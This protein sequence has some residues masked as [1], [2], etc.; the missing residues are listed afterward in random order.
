[1]VFFLKMYFWDLAA[2]FFDFVVLFWDVLVRIYFGTGFLDVRDW[3]KR[4][5][6][7]FIFKIGVE[8]FRK[9]HNSILRVRVAFHLAAQIDSSFSLD[10]RI[11]AVWDHW[12]E[13]VFIIILRILF[14]LRLWDFLNWFRTFWDVFGDLPV[15][16]I[17]IEKIHLLFRHLKILNFVPFSLIDFPFFDLLPTIDNDALDGLG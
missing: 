1:M 14:P 5:I 10:I 8:A 4:H 13:V 16:T 6:R 17:A 15:E 2:D 3:A 7:A 9:L 12:L 11:W